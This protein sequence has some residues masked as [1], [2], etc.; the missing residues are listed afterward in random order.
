LV[1]W[2]VGWLVSLPSKDPSG[3]ST[4]IEC[5]EFE[6]IHRAA[7]VVTPAETAAAAEKLKL[8]KEQLMVRNRSHGG[9][10]FLAVA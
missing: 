8:E 5:S 9:C 3:T 1:V 6:R 7:H 4:I 10:L 2:S